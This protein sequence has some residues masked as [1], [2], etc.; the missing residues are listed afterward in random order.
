MWLY[1]A[2]LRA[3]AWRSGAIPSSRV[4]VFRPWSMASLAAWRTTSG[5]GVSHTPWARLIPRNR[6]HSTD[7]TRIS[8]WAISLAIAL[9]FSMV[10]TPYLLILMEQL[11]LAKVE[12]PPRPAVSRKKHVTFLFAKSVTYEGILRKG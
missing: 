8:D 5:A 2:S 7:I 10:G 3:M 4:Y 1:S 12:K 11:A 6:S 9:T